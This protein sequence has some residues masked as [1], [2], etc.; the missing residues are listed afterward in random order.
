MLGESDGNQCHR[1]VTCIW[2][3]D[4]MGRLVRLLPPE[5]TIF[6]ASGGAREKGAGSG[7]P[8]G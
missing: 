2:L 4:V 5:I 6:L 1:V 7:R 8:V 3:S